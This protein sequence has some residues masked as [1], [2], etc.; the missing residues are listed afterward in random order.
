[1]KNIPIETVGKLRSKVKGRIVLPGEPDYDEVR[2][3]WNAMIDRRPLSSCSA[4]KRM[5]SQMQSLLHARMGW[6]YQFEVRD[7]TLRETLYVITA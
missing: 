1:M 3:I 7:I 4:Q 6:R 2:K 5:T